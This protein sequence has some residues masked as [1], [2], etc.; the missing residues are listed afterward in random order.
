M[1]AV[2][3]ALLCRRFLALALAVTQKE[4]KILHG[5]Y[6]LPLAKCMH[7]YLNCM[8]A[9]NETSCRHMRGPFFNC[10]ENQ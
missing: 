3:L 9:L 5:F 1:L 2:S 4:K 8:Y 10:F 6:S 7:K